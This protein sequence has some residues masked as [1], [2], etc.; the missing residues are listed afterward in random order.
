MAM[1]ILQIRAD[2]PGRVE[3]ETVEGTGRLVVNGFSD[4]EFYFQSVFADLQCSARVLLAI[5]QLNFRDSGE[6]EFGKV[7]NG[8]LNTANDDRFF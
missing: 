7:R 3:R 8:V 4:S 2:L 6:S 1:A 5:H